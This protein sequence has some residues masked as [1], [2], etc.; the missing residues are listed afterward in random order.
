MIED[1]DPVRVRDDPA[2]DAA[3]RADLSR[4]AEHPSLEFDVGAE[5]ARLRAAIGAGGTGTG[6]TGG[7][8]VAGSAS[9]AGTAAGST[10]SVAT[11]GLGAGVALALVAGLTWLAD[12]RSRSAGDGVPGAKEPSA[13]SQT[14][15]AM[16]PATGE[17]AH[18]GV[19][20]E[21]ASATDA[22]P[23]ETREPAQAWAAPNGASQAGAP[24]GDS[25]PARIDPRIE[26]DHMARLRSTLERDPA[27]ALAMARD[28][29]ERFRPGLFAEEREATAVLALHR[30]ARHAEAREAGKRF[31]RRYP[32]SA[33]AERVRQIVRKR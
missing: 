12:G 30:L 17:A 8:E 6:S 3:L 26:L 27:Q 29:Q 23:N 31:L 33:F 22:V 16:P 18:A 7:G 11:I 5:L 21:P 1:R 32:E 2:A 15:K 10:G 25:P 19:E 9:V 4:A 20:R 24:S 14:S 28:G 13:A